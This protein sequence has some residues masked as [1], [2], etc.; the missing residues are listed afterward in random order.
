MYLCI[1]P[2]KLQNHRSSGLHSLD[3]VNL[4]HIRMADVSTVKRVVLAVKTTSERV[5]E[6]FC[7]DLG[8]G[9]IRSFRSKGTG[10]NSERKTSIT[11]E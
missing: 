1:L 9:V 8:Q 6:P 11:N 7:A 4:L 3:Y 10:E 5:A 2:K